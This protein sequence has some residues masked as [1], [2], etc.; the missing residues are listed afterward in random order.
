MAAIYVVKHEESGVHR[1]SDMLGKGEVI[2]YQ[3][4]NTAAAHNYLHMV[5]SSRASKTPVL[6]PSVNRRGVR[7]LDPIDRKVG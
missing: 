3:A 5:N 7:N 4:P 6:Q 1:I 2:A